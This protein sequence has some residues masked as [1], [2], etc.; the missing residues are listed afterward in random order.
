MKRILFI[1]KRTYDGAVCAAIAKVIERHTDRV[2]DYYV[3]DR[4]TANDYVFEY[5]SSHIEDDISIYICGHCI[6]SRTAEKLKAM[7]DNGTIVF[8][9][10][11]HGITSCA[12]LHADTW[13][14][15]AIS[16]LSKA[17]KIDGDLVMKGM[18]AYVE[19]IKGFDIHEYHIIDQ[20]WE[21][22]FKIADDIMVGG[23]N[24]EKLIGK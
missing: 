14:R 5:I 1:T 19:A 6:T 11:Y 15:G 17:K 16:I 7:Q 13:V 12:N 4:Q 20:Y 10:R 2:F 21:T 24:H 3:G 23:K 18:Y 8:H 22:V 9:R